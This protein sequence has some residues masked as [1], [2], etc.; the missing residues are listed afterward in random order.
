MNHK[1]LISQVRGKAEAIYTN[2][3][4]RA[5]FRVFG[6]QA[7]Q[8]FAI[9]GNAR[10]GSNYLLDGLKSS[11]SIRTYHEI[12][13][14]HNREVGKDFDKI[15]STVFQYESKSTK[16]VGFKVFYNHLTDEEWQK[17]LSCSDLKVIHLTRKNRLRTVIS[18]EIAF[19]TGQW[20]KSSNSGGPREK[21]VMLEPSKLIK[22]LEQIEEGEAA[23]RSRFCD[24]PILEV[25]Y[26]EL[27]Q[28][29]DRVFASVGAYL[30]AD[31]IDPSKI[32]L[33]RQ[34]PESLAQLIINYDEIE[35]LLKDTRFGEYLN[36]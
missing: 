36:S 34:N 26:E 25:V 1:E 7:A 19:K 30:G 14:S 4:Q 22:R 28:Y 16:L 23:T 20:T 31:G 21:R 15:L 3:F 2:T 5:Y 6:H 10:T 29:P 33:K 13:A 12:F 32:R 35:S 17:L 24:R 11:P 27:V 9:V 8:R 18:L